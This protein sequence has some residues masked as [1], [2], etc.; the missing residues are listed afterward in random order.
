MVVFVKKLEG[1]HSHVRESLI[2]YNLH[3]SCWGLRLSDRQAGLTGKRLLTFGLDFPGHLC[4]VAMFCCW[5]DWCY[6]LLL[7]WINLLGCCC[8]NQRYINSCPIGH[9]SPEHK[10]RVL[11]LKILSI[12][13]SIIHLKKNKKQKMIIPHNRKL[14]RKKRG[15]VLKIHNHKCLLKTGTQ[16]MWPDSQNRLSQPSVTCPPVHR[17][18]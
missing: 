5:N 11:I 16:W 1:L 4:R 9:A 2:S 10:K 13:T 6:L 8:I 15:L 14:N 12:S 7:S 18:L 17:Y 3:L